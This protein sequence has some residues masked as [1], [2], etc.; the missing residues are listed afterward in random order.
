[1]VYVWLSLLQ[2]SECAK[3]IRELVLEVSMNTFIAVVSVRSKKN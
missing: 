1:M 3:N 2:D